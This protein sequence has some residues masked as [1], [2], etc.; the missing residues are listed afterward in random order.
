MERIEFTLAD[1]H[2]RIMMPKGSKMR[3]NKPGCVQIWHPHTTRLV[4]S[5][6]L[7]SPAGPAAA[8]YKTEATLSNGARVRYDVDYDIGGGSGGAEGELKGQFNLASRVL[9]LTCRDQ[10]EWGNAPSWCLS[11]L[12]TLQVQDRP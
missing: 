10:G 12:R 4:K 9:A 5:L 6:E 2:Y 7:C 8:S 3:G 1:A 11:Y